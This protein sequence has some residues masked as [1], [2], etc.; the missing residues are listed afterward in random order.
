MQPTSFHSSHWAPCNHNP[1]LKPTCGIAVFLLSMALVLIPKSS[2]THALFLQP[3]VQLKNTEAA[4]TARVLDA[5]TQPAVGQACPVALLA[6]APVLSGAVQQFNC[7][8]MNSPQHAHQ[9]IFTTHSSRGVPVSCSQALHA[10]ARNVVLRSSEGGLSRGQKFQKF[11][12]SGICC[13]GCSCGF[14]TALDHCRAA[15]AARAQLGRDL[16]ASRGMRHVLC[17]LYY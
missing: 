8:R 10:A 16:R 17:R 12:N 1:L 6:E 4:E 5:T 2:K 15:L 9:A 13:G 3:S 7:A 11:Q 14:A